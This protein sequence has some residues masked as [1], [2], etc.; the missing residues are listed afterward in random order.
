MG[1]KHK[2]R[3]R[4]NKGRIQNFA[5]ATCNVFFSPFQKDKVHFADLQSEN[6]LGGYK[7]KVVYHKKL[8]FR[9]GAGFLI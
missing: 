5:R 7:S 3:N 2:Y 6:I 8:V 9:S 4:A 1:T